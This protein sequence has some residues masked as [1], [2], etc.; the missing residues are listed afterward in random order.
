MDPTRCKSHRRLVFIP[1]GVSEFKTGGRY[2]S[3]HL[4]ERGLPSCFFLNNVKRV[5]QRPEDSFRSWDWDHLI[6]LDLW[7]TATSATFLQWTV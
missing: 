5:R 1:L 2:R 7:R 6:E 4:S 3:L